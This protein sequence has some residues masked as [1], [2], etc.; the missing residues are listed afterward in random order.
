MV[1]EINQI[2][3]ANSKPCLGNFLINLAS[4]SGVTKIVKIIPTLY[5]T[6]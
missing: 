5:N 4:V 2:Q 6:G 3:G 1:P